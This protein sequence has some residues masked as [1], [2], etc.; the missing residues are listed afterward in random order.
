MK[1]KT[2]IDLAGLS[3]FFFTRALL[4]FRAEAHKKSTQRGSEMDL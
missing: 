2:Q 1:K 4:S 3:P